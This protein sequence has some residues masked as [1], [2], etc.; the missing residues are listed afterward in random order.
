MESTGDV[1]C[2]DLAQTMPSGSRV[3][4]AMI[5]VRLHFNFDDTAIGKGWLQIEGSPEGYQALHKVRKAF[6]ADFDES[7]ELNRVAK[8]IIPQPKT[9][10]FISRTV[11]LLVIRSGESNFS[12]DEVVRTGYCIVLVAAAIYGSPK[13]TVRDP[14]GLNGKQR[15]TTITFEADSIHMIAGRCTISIPDETILFCVMLCI[16]RGSI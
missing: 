9:R 13:V 1:N 12:D 6:W 5:D 7:E 4:H 14:Q 10:F 15:E 3:R 16:R 8:V 2:L 11:Q